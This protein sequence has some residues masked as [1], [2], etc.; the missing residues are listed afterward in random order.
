MIIAAVPGLTQIFISALIKVIGF[1]A[2]GVKKFTL[3][4][5]I[6]S[7]VYGGFIAKKSIFAYL[8]SYG[9]LGMFDPTMITLLLLGGVIFYYFMFYSSG[10][11]LE[12]SKWRFKDC[13]EKPSLTV[14]KSVKSVT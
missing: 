6:Q 7:K 5:M 14:P 13:L 4:A 12:H 9:A 8:Q 1:T 11:K 3:A 2:V 10:Y